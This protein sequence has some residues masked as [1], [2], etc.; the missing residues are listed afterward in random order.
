MPNPFNDHT[1]IYYNLPENGNVEIALFDLAG[2]K[3][4]IVAQ[5]NFIKGDG[6]IRLDS[7]GLQPGCYILKFTFSGNSEQKSIN[8]K[9]IIR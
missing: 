6:K 8:K 9:L 5:D 2:K 1:W 4:F 3:Q 7:Q